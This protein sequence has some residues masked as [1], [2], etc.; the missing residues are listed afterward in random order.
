MDC[1]GTL[2]PSGPGT[3]LWIIVPSAETTSWT[4]VCSLQISCGIRL[5]IWGLG[6]ECQANQASATNEECTVAWGICN[7][8]GSA[9]TKRISADAGST[10]S[11]PST[12][13]AS[14]DGLRLVKYALW[15][16]ETGSFRN[17]V[18]RASIPEH[19]SRRRRGS[20]RGMGHDERDACI[21][22]VRSYDG[23]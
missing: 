5:L 3:S 13:T 6:I 7:V 1:S 18:G 17:M 10:N 21:S 14:P 4:F 12:S 9:A 8:S 16:T 2:W 20:K 22:G 15:T 19:S 11:T 23:R